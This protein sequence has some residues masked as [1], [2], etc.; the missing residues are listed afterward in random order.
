MSCPD[1]NGTGEYIGLNE[2][3][4]C[5]TCGGNGSKPITWDPADLRPSEEEKSWITELLNY[6]GRFQ[7]VSPNSSRDPADYSGFKILQGSGGD[8]LWLEPEEEE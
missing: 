1:C 8:L 6:Y 4:P 3:S 2:K 7:N 5:Q